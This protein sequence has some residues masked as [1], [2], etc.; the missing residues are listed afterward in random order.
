M[1]IDMDEVNVVDIVGMC[2]VKII[3]LWWDKEVLKWIFYK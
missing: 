2:F 1:Y 3:K